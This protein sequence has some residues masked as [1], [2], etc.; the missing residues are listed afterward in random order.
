MLRNM[1][2]DFK[3]IFKVILSIV[4]IYGGFWVILLFCIYNHDTDYVWNPF[5]RDVVHTGIKV[6]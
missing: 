5:V 4:L 6:A 1:W 2:E 3:L